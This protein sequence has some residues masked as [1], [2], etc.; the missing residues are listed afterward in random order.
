M[1][2]GAYRLRVPRVRSLIHSRGAQ[3]ARCPAHAG[4]GGEIRPAGIAGHVIDTDQALLAGGVD[5]G[6]VPGFLLFEIQEPR[7]LA[8]DGLGDKLPADQEDQ[9][10]VR[11]AWVPCG[12]K[13]RPPE[14]GSQHPVSTR[15]CLRATA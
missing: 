1:A 13:Q 15:V 5:T 14:P 12:F 7:G 10:S 4:F 6:P 8:G 3:H 2:F 9:P 11:G